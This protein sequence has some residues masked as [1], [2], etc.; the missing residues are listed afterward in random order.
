MKKLFALCSI[1]LLTFASGLSS[2][3]WTQVSTHTL[4]DAV[5]KE[6][7]IEHYALDAKCAEIYRRDGVYYIKHTF[8]KVPARGELYSFSIFSKNNQVHHLYLSDRPVYSAGMETAYLYRALDADELEDLLPK[9]RYKEPAAAVEV[10]TQEYFEGASPVA[11]I[12]DEQKVK[13]YCYSFG[14]ERARTYF[15][16]VRHPVNKALQP[17]TGILY[18]ADVSLSVA[19]TAVTWVGFNVP[20]IIGAVTLGYLDTAYNKLFPSKIQAPIQNIQE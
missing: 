8:Y 2:C 3:V 15:E 4:V 19:T 5:G 11:V 18:V 12:T 6:E 10:L 7:Y 1:L 17:I 14:R 20:V 9:A 16:P 13:Y